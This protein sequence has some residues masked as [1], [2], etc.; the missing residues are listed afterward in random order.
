MALKRQVTAVNV[1]P[2]SKIR[3]VA[4]VKSNAGIAVARYV[5]KFR[6]DVQPLDLKTL[7]EM[8]NVRARSASHIEQGPRRGVSLLDDREDLARF[9]LVV[10]ARIHRVIVWRH[11]RMGRRHGFSPKNSFALRMDASLS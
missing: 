4:K 2:R 9:L 3:H 6:A 7:P 1:S 10:L 11:L 5:E 8:R